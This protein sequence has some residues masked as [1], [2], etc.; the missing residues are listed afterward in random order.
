MNE[1]ILELIEKEEL[2]NVNYMNKTSKKVKLLL[3]KHGIFIDSVELISGHK[4]KKARECYIFL[5][6]NYVFIDIRSLSIKFA[7]IYS[8]MTSD[9]DYHK[10]DLM[11][12][13]KFINIIISY[14]INNCHK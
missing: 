7:R 6:G 2:I 1:Y 12:I 4:R 8:I 10:T 9:L 14:Y 5:D 3:I 13:N 11:Y